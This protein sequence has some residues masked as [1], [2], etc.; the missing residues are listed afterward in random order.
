M[1]RLRSELVEHLSVLI[2]L[3]V[4]ALLVVAG[5]V[6]TPRVGATQSNLVTFETVTFDNT[7]GGVGFTATTIRPS[8]GPI[9]Q[10]CSGK[11]EA[12][13]I[14]YRYDAGAPTT[15]VGALADIGDVITI[16]GLGYLGAFMGIRTGGTSGVVNFHCTRD[17]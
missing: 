4:T 3:L 8:G 17:P 16:H 5:V 7:S 13:Q 10:S 15:T 9:M 12:G 1:R 14:R 6:L 2:A 11:L